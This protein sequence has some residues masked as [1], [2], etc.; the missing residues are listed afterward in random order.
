MSRGGHCFGEVEDEAAQGTAWAEEGVTGGAVPDLFAADGVLLVGKREGCVRDVRN[1]FVITRAGGGGDE[2]VAD[3]EGD[4][5]EAEGLGVPSR[6]RRLEVLG[7]AHEPE[8][9]DDGEVTDG[10][11]GGTVVGVGE[12]EGV[13]EVA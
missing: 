12:V 8:E 10:P 11:I 7:G 9:G 1:V 3:G 6:G 13:V 4:V 5:L 2:S